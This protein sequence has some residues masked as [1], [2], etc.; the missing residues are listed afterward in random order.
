M[1]KSNAGASVN[2][3][4]PTTRKVIL[5]NVQL[6]GSLITQDTYQDISFHLTVY[7]RELHQSLMQAPWIIKKGVPES[8]T[9]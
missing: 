9:R 7:L 1:K 6:L 2:Q 8:L 3:H 5:I 4:N